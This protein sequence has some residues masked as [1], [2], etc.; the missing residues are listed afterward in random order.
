MRLL[1]ED[2]IRR[3]L[4]DKTQNLHNLHRSLARRTGS[5][6]LNANELAKALELACASVRDCVVCQDDHFGGIILLKKETLGETFVALRAAETVI[7]D[8]IACLITMS[9]DPATD[10]A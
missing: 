5:E 8:V 6:P 7:K 10:P 4:V 3:D 2:E 1:F 9:P